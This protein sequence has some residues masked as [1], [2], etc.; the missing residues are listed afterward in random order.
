[1]SHHVILCTMNNVRLYPNI[2]HDEGLSTSEKTT[3]KPEGKINLNWYHNSF[4]WIRVQNYIFI[5]GKKTLQ[6]IHRD[7]KPSK[8]HEMG[9]NVMS[10]VKGQYHHQSATIGS[11]FFFSN[12]LVKVWA[13]SMMNMLVWLFVNMLT[14][15]LKYIS[16]Y[17]VRRI[18]V[19]D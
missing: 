16:D 11:L 8:I 14:E 1:M 5:F 15:T 7:T 18:Y 4:G 2:P 3:Q 9:S 12:V 19:L 6:D 13:K 10:L 17:V